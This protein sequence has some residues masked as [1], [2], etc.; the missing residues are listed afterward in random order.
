MHTFLLLGLVVC[1]IL[2]VFFSD[3]LKAAISLAGASVFLAMIFF[4]LGATYAGVFE[5]SVVAGLITVLFIATISL[6][7]KEEGI[8]HNRWMRLLFPLVFMGFV[9]ID[10]VVVRQYLGGLTALSGPAETGGFGRVFWGGRTFDLVAQIA[11]ILAGVF[12]VL[13]LFR[14]RSGDE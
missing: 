5:I 4:E 3:L 1:S 12:C 2:A 11:I 8:K 13:A 9:L 10:F 7:K 14:K 6:T